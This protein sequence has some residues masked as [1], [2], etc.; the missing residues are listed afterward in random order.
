ME[1]RVRLNTNRRLTLSFSLI[2]NKIWHD[3]PFVSASRVVPPS[4][5]LPP[6]HSPFEKPGQRNRPDKALARSHFPS[7]F[8]VIEMT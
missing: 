5:S 1:R 3:F 7:A 4:P 6:S 8:M 2:I